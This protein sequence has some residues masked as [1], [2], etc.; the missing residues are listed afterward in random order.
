MSRSLLT[1]MLSLL[2]AGPVW[3]VENETLTTFDYSRLQLHKVDSHWHLM[4]GEALVKDLG[5]SEADAREALAVIHELKLTQ[6]G[7][8]GTRAPVLEYWLADKAAPRGLIRSERLQTIDRVTLR[9]ESVEGQWVLRDARQVWFNFGRFEA[10][11]RQAL[12]VF[13][14]Y[15]FNRIGYVG[16]PTPVLIY[17][18][19]ATDGQTAAPSKL[20]AA[21]SPITAVQLCQV[22]QLT[23]VSP[24]TFNAATGEEHEPLDWRRAELCRDGNSWKLRIG[25]EVLADFGSRETEAREALRIV[26]HY[27]FTER[28]LIGASATPF[29]FYLVNGQPP[30]GL[31]FGLSNT[32]FASE[33]L[34]V[35]QMDG[36]WLICDGQRP[37]LRGGDSEADAKQILKAIQRYRFDNWCEIGGSDQ[38]G[39]RFLVRER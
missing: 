12:S 34:A 5:S 20:P 11:A 3:A 1:F 30:R 22:R 10:D 19:E 7:V 15:P 37:I 29:A 38:G 33:S 36:K 9:I 35:R 24:L 32:S 27:R 8:I 16:F 21:N 13:Q 4:A 17:F 26:Q 25:S 6:R 23:L 28:C 18:V 14:R 31:A 2:L 39:L